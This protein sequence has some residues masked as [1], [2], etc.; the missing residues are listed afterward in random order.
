MAHQDQDKT[1]MSTVKIGQRCPDSEPP[2]CRLDVVQER[3][4]VLGCS[5]VSCFSRTTCDPDVHIAVG[6]KFLG[7]NVPF[8]LCD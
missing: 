5:L 4:G 1:R 8:C 6:V 7:A 2:E 3:W